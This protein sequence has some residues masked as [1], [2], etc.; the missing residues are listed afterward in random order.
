MRLRRRT[1]PLLPLLLCAAVTP[2]RALPS[3]LTTPIG[4]YSGGAKI[5][6]GDVLSGRVFEHVLFYSGMD[7][8]G[9]DF[10]KS[11]LT[12]CI[13][14]GTDLTR[15]IFTGA[16]L[17]FCT[18][19]DATFHQTLGPDGGFITDLDPFMV[20]AKGSLLP[21]S[22]LPPPSPSGGA[23][24]SLPLSP[25]TLPFHLEAD[26]KAQPPPVPL[27]ATYPNLKTLQPS[28]G[29][30]ELFQPGLA[31]G[32]VRAWPLEG[33]V[34]RLVALDLGLA[35]HA[36]GSDT[37]LLV[38]QDGAAR[39]LHVG[40]AA[41]D[42]GGA[43]NLLGYTTG[44]RSTFHLH[45]LATTLVP[46]QP[47]ERV[48]HSKTI[49]P[50]ESKIRLASAAF[51]RTDLWLL[52]ND[53]KLRMEPLPG[54]TAPPVTLAIGDGG[55]RG[56]LVS[57]HGPVYKKGNRVGLVLAAQ[58]KPEVLEFTAHPSRPVFGMTLTAEGGL[59][60]SVR[61]EDALYQ[62]HPDSE[63]V[64]KIKRIPLDAK[65]AGESD[66]VEGPDRCLWFTET[67]TPAI[68]RFNPDTGQVTRFPL[69]KGDLK[70]EKLVH[71]PHGKLYFLLGGG[72][73]LGSISAVQPEAAP[74]AASG[75]TAA[76]TKSGH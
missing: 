44:D 53:R 52:G 15:A 55:G 48:R 36:A 42:L 33:K 70:P 29:L 2:A 26:G 76:Q 61:G 45:V 58:E 13:F 47:L 12:W 73:R 60:Y 54:S 68:G 28:K 23:A 38:T 65:N 21:L 1:L 72:T 24:L 31:L 41:A 75:A 17:S 22:P 64:L 67:A 25:M 18:A 57:A 56:E 4:E 62:A 74:G 14:D 34:D 8:Q 43:E 46:G 63:G 6:A 5:L 37:I 40:A 30:E 11:T 16:S 71:G 50:P 10:S 32:T 51:S 39:R 3:D 69:G 27:P 19:L 35:L 49:T 9:A 20:N 7:L 66:L 59:F